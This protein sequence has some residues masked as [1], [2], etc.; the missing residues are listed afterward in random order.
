MSW[1]TNQTAT[2][3]IHTMYTRMI[4][5]NAFSHVTNRSIQI[6]LSEVES[7]HGDLT[8][9]HN[10]NE[11]RIGESMN[12]LC[13]KSFLHISCHTKLRVAPGLHNIRRLTLLKNRRKGMDLQ[14]LVAD[15][16]QRSKHI[17]FIYGKYAWHMHI[18]THAR[19]RRHTHAHEQT[20]TTHTHTS[21]S[22]H[23]A[24]VAAAPSP[25][26]GK[27]IHTHTRTHT[28]TRT[29]THTLTHAH[30][31]RLPKR[32]N[33]SKRC[34]SSIKPSSVSRFDSRDGESRDGES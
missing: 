11:D 12:T 15:A 4:R 27:C 26:E 34:N 3:H 9:K 21:T 19:T 33:L 22:L 28:C 32:P 14:P 24:E 8:S 13:K 25:D 29:Y 31:Y 30:A 1:K 16:P 5:P 17:A 10:I 20:Y 6:F 18:H 7:C 2:T 23:Q